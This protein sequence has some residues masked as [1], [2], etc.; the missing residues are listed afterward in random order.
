MSLKPQNLIQAAEADV[1]RRAKNELIA[2]NK[3]LEPYEQYAFHRKHVNRGVTVRKILELALAEPNI[4]KPI[5]VMDKKTGKQKVNPR[6]G[7][8]KWR[9][10]KTKR[11]TK[12]IYEEPELIRAALAMLEKA[13]VEQPGHPATPD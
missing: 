5:R 7:K 12:R 4:V 6:T 10:A 9:N 3:W 2:A 11:I 13:N 1:K 8:W